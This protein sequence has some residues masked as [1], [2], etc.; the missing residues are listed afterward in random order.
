M[1]IGLGVCIGVYRKEGM[2]RLEFILKGE[3]TEVSCSLLHRCRNEI[4]IGGGGTCM[5]K[6]G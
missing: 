5:K 6:N 2:Y 3:D 1:C 4:L